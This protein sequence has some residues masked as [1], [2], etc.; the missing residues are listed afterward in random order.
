MSICRSPEWYILSQKTILK[1][2]NSYIELKAIEE[3]FCQT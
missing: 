2:L 1:H 3:G